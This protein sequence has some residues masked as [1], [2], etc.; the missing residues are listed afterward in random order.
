MNRA[1]PVPLL[2]LVICVLLSSPAWGQ[3]NFVYTNDD[4]FPGN[5]VSGFSVSVNTTLTPVPG[6]P[7]STGGA[8]SGSGFFSANR[9]TTVKN[10]LYSSNSTSSDVSAFTIDPASG[11]LKPIEGSP[12]PAG[13]I[14][15]SGIS[16]AATPDG[17]FLF[18]GKGYSSDI[19]TFS[20]GPNG[21]LTPLGP[22]LWLGYIQDGVSY[23]KVSPDGRF[24]A[25]TIP[26]AH[27]IGMFAIANNGSLTPVPGSPFSADGEGAPTGLEINC[28]SDLL[29]AGETFG[30]ATVFVY[31]IAADGVL[32]PQPGSP[33]TAPV[34]NGAIG[35]LLSED[36]KHL[37][38]SN[39]FSDSISVFEVGSDGVLTPGPLFP[40]ESGGLP[41]GIAINE[42]STVLYTAN[43][44]YLTPS[45]A[46]FR[47]LNSGVLTAVAGSP[48]NTGQ[49]EG[50]LSLTAFP[51]RTCAIRVTIDI[52]P[53]SSTNPIN[54]KARGKIPVAILSTTA[55]NAA[56]MIAV[57]TITFGEM[58]DERSLAFCNSAEEDINGDGLPDLLCHFNIQASGFHE[59]D[60]EGVLKAKTVDGR[61]IE[62]MDAIRVVGP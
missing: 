52:K 23:V 26:I 30:N 37:F 33:F 12:F 60:T 58:G 20:I 1:L 48:L 29:F 13:G 31:S 10:F 41:S 39:T 9:I 42:T 15:L 21:G 25:V 43:F 61:S 56:R 7:F 62:G 38:V 17:R 44:S 50:L 53:G 8:G 24:L 19:T 47:V 40:V 54:I 16:L 28:A 32:T 57:G 55:F 14:G 4:L 11:E 22:P 5:T 27:R 45:I 51:P 35:L 2:R 49:P 34:G 3:A 46:A 6:S 59:G 36:E 18:A